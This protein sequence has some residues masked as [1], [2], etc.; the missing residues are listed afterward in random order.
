[1]KDRASLLTE[2]R[3]PQSS[4][5]DAMSTQQILAIMDEQN[6][7]AV[8]AVADARA[9]IACAVELVVEQIGAG[10]RLVYVGAGTSGGLAVL[11]AAEV[12]VTFGTERDIVQAVFAGG[13]DTAGQFADVSAEDSAAAGEAAIDERAV[14]SH[15]VV[16]G[17]AAG[18]TTPFV[19]GALAAARRRGSRTIFLCCVAPFAG[20]PQADVIIRLLTGPEVVTGST[21]LKA[22]TATKLALNAITTTAMVRLGKVY[23]NL[24]VEMQAKGCAKIWDRGA[25]IVAA[26]SGADHA[27]AV[28]LL[29]QA[30]GSIRHAILMHMRGID[31]HK[32]SQLLSSHHGSLRA[33]LGEPG[34]R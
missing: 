22:G 18:G 17:I 27:R 15:D 25:R 11:D 34:N 2:Q 13:L 9:A 3:L 10:G 26:I 32:A 1:M 5:L 16:M 21:R 8:A 14:D 24:L 7:R 33:A 4:G 31:L 20:E 30:D 19:H 23:D 12:P 28:Q 6:Q 29:E